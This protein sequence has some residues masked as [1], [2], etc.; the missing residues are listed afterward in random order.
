M[1]KF[2]PVFF[3]LL[4]CASSFCITEFA[5]SLQLQL[6]GVDDLAAG[7]KLM[8]KISSTFSAFIPILIV[9]FLFFTSDLCLNTIFDDGISHSSLFSVIGYAFIP[10][11]I[12]LY[13][14]WGNLIYFSARANIVNVNDFMSMT[15]MFGL[16]LDEFGH[17]STACWAIIYLAMIL[18]L[19][20]KN[21]NLIH[22]IVSTLLPSLCVVAVYKLI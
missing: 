10:M 9:G 5:N 8:F 11:V 3:V 6:S 16:T 7:Y 21:I 18:Y 19:Y 1:K 12:Y 15:M 4:A 17:I 14:F 20:F 13:V 2:F 22:A